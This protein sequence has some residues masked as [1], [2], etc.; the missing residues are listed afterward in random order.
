MT[1]VYNYIMG[2]F[3]GLCVLAWGIAEPTATIIGAVAAVVA[4]GMAA[5]NLG[6]TVRDMKESD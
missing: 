4:I 1:R 2:I 6:V 3:T 5:F